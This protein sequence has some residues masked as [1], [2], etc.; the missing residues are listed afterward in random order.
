MNGRGET[1]RSPIKP[2]GDRRPF[3]SRAEHTHRSWGLDP[4]RTPVAQ[5]DG[6]AHLADAPDY[7]CIGDFE[8]DEVGAHALGW[9]EVDHT[10]H[11]LVLA[12]EQD[13]MTCLS[14]PPPP[15]QTSM[16]IRIFVA[17]S[18]HT[19]GMKPIYSGS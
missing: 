13:K 18:M 9:R 14:L 8:L 2:A 5:D 15:R 17:T 19:L 11:S 10:L 6:D 1:E 12:P 3:V 16:L 4:L 7:F